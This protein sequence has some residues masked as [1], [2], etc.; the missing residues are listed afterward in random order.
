HLGHAVEAGDL[1]TGPVLIRAHADADV[2]P[3]VAVD[4]IVAATAFDDVA[5]A[6]TENDVARCKARNGQVGCAQQLGQA[7]DQRNVGEGSTRGATVIEDGDRINIVTTQNVGEG[8]A[9]KPLDFR[10]AVEN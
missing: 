6:A 8:R 2:E 5:T 1:G 3:L 4:Q 9:R 10:E 7:I